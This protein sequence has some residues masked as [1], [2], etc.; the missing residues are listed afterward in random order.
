MKSAFGLL[1]CA[2]L[3]AGQSL[4]SVLTSNNNTSTLVKLVQ[5][6]PG[7]LDQLSAAKDITILAP[8]NAAFSAFTSQNPSA[9]NDTSLVA[10]VLS[11]HVLNGTI[12]AG[13]ILN[14]TGPLFAHSLLTNTTYENVTGGQYVE[15]EATKGKVSFVSGL[16]SSS[17]VVTANVAFDGGVIHIIDKVLTV[18]AKIS[19]TAID[20]GLSALAG[21]LTK[22]GLVSAVEGLSNI[23]VF[24]PSNAAFNAIGSVVANVSNTTLTSVLEYHVIN[25][26]V[27]FSTDLTDGAKVPTLNGDEVTIHKSGANFFVNDALIVTPNVLVANGV[28]HVIDQ[29]LNPANATA[30][31]AASATAG[32]PQYSGASTST[33]AALTSGIPA[34]STTIGAGAT[35]ASMSG[36]GVASS[37]AGATNAAA[38]YKPLPIAGVIAVGAALFL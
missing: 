34:P 25:S 30:S 28:V 35:G 13:Q 32:A 27:I 1:T 22:A 17:N 6:V 16:L 31:Q 33:V 18:P 29:V 23:T 7:L 24:A 11:Y 37:T 8:D 15:A 5:S 14:A 2:A 9:A 26:S 20:A 3:A 19:T 10:A 21:A 38:G 4:T 36:S 12:Q